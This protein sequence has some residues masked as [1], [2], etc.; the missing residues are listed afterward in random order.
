MRILFRLIVESASIALQA[1]VG[2]LL[3]TALALLGVFVGIFLIVAVLTAVDTIEKGLRDGIES[4]GTQV[5][6]VQKWPWSFDGENYAWWKYMNRPQPD[7]EDLEAIQELS[8][9]SEAA[10]FMAGSSRTIKVGNS[11][12][13]NVSLVAA[14]HGYNE[15]RSFDLAAGR[16]FREVESRAGNNVAIIGSDVALGLFGLSNPLDKTIRI[17]N[18]KATVIGVFAQEG[19]SII[20]VSN[21]NLVLIPMNFGNNFLDIRGGRMD[22]KIMVKAHEGVKT[23]ALQDELMGLL[24]AHRRIKPREEENFALNEVSILSEAFDPIFLSLKVVGWFLGG[25]ALLVGGFGTANIM[26]VSVS[27]RTNIIGI[28]KSLGAK[29]WFVLV[30][31]LIE[32]VVLCLIGGLVGI[33][34]VTLAA[35]MINLF[36][37]FTI[38]LSAGRIIFGLLVSTIIG[39]LAGIIPAILAARLNPVDAI[40]SK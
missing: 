33:L 17:G 2:N 23:E 35:V 8:E 3:R 25:L 1:L 12:M 9:L 10:T 38:Y 40:R 29:N 6:F 7:M 21:D 19:E 4:L 5:V 11:S 37:D 28:Q 36:S 22:Q 20:D 34:F 14:S 13:N 16:Y 15:V 31:F 18:V 26:Y 27:E 32:S 30:Q 24:R 39:L